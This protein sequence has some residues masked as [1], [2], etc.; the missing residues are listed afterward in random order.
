MNE[1]FD[2]YIGAGE[3][4]FGARDAALLRAIDEH[5]SIHRAATETGR[6]YAHAQRRVV[7]LEDAFG[8]LVERQRGGAG[9]GG[10]T[11]TATASDVLARYDRLRTALSG[12]ARAEETTFQGTV[13]ERTGELGVVET[14]TGAIR[15][16]VP[17]DATTVEVSV[18]SDAVTLTAPDQAPRKR[19][20]S[21]RNR[22]DGRITAL[23]PG[24]AVVRATVDVGVDEP[25]VA[26]LTRASADYLGL[27][28]DT[29][30]VATFKATA[31]QAT[32]GHGR[33]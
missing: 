1:V 6:S 17:P 13:R 27:E 19:E 29:E 18:R 33:D 32:P 4:A 11:L 5:G 21:A 10:S 26:L 31:T 16:L 22:L 12:V 8:S 7:E 28:P 2:A 15:A 25:L 20:T 14:A 30:V 9:G 23:D 24:E 3:I